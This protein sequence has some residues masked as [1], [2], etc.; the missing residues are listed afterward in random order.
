MR[1]MSRRFPVY[2]MCKMARN[3]ILAELTYVSVFVDGRQ[4]WEIMDNMRKRISR[5][6]IES[7]R[8][9]AIKVCS[10]TLILQ[11]QRF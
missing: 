9:E 6:D 7:E 11:T 4:R 8:A 1:N 5:G 10:V 3:Y 2:D